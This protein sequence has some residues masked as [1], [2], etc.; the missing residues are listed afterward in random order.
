LKIDLN[1]LDLI[2]QF[3][4]IITTNQGF[5]IPIA[6]LSFLVFI[7]KRNTE[8]QNQENNIKQIFDI[9]NNINKN[10]INQPYY[11][12]FLDNLDKGL[13]FTN[14]SIRL[15]MDP[16]G[17]SL[18]IFKYFFMSFFQNPINWLFITIL[19]WTVYKSYYS[20]RVRNIRQTYL[21]NRIDSALVRS[22]LGNTMRLRLF[23]WFYNEFYKKST[24]F[25]I[26]F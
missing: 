9:I 26:R 21:N 16:N 11:K 14:D 8:L 12:N 18:M 10:F 7:W 22:N 6:F 25:F 5:Y 23:R 13:I 4:R 1:N 15:A 3:F 20:I 24:L 2:N 19:K 17:Y